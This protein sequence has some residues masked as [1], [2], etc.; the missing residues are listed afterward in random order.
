MKM[1][2][3]NHISK[4]MIVGLGVVLFNSTSVSAESDALDNPVETLLECRQ[5][6][7]VTVRLQCFDDAAAALEQSQIK[8]DIAI[9]RR[10]DIRKTRRALFGLS[11]PNLEQLDRFKDDNEEIDRFIGIVRNV[12]PLRGGRYTVQIDESVWQTTETGYFNRPPRI[13]AEAV[14]T[15]GM[16]GS[17][18][19]SIDGKSGLKAI[20]IR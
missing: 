16:L 14:V 2:R 4:R 20:R 19:L 13:G 9:I 1:D 15:R 3:R 12:T 17:Y 18:R 5:V 6:T 8:G 7:E 11:V 10:E